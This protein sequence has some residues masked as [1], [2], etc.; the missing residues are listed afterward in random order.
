MKVRIT[1]PD[2][3]LSE[4]DALVGPR[5]RTGFLERAVRKEVKRERLRLSLVAAR[6][7][8]AGTPGWRSPDE[9]IQ[10]VDEL[11]SDDRDPWES[12]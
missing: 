2:T 10:F 12:S 11:R 4:I 7:A 8:M 6:G 3:L 1:I 5:G 9:I